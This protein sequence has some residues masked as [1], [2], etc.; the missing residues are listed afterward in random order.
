MEEPVFSHHR[1][2]HLQMI[3]RHEHC[4]LIF[5]YFNATGRKY[6]LFS[7]A[8]QL[9]GIF[10]FGLCVCQSLLSLPFPISHL[11]SQLLV[12]TEVRKHPHNSEYKSLSITDSTVFCRMMV[13]FLFLRLKCISPRLSLAVFLSTRY[14]N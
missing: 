1:V 13:N 12:R 8:G 3:I 4:L 10:S 14:P 9:P 5:S 7:H 11:L 2:F 6:W